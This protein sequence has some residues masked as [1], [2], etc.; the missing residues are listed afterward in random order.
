VIQQALAGAKEC[1]PGPATVFSLWRH[2]GWQ[3]EEFHKAQKTGCNVEDP[4]FET[5][6]A[7]QPMI[8]LLSAVAVLLL[9][10]RELS[11]DEATAALP[12]S[13]V[14]AEEYVEVLS[15][16]RYGEKRALTVR[17]F[18]LALGRLGGHLNR[19]SDGLPGWLVLWRGWTK[20]Q[21]LVEG[22]RVA[23]R[24]QTRVSKGGHK[25]DSPSG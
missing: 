10:L 18:V 4:Q 16:K 3:I 19:R 7:L 14:V 17:E 23:Q 20:L 11:R 25:S 2:Y 13:A 6:E 21:L 24:A 1:Q 22:Y 9:N 5:A 12:A 8:A 15:L